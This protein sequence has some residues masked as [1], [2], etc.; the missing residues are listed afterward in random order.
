QLPLAR[1]AR[2][3]GASQILPVGFLLLALSFFSVALFAGTTA[4]DTLWRLLPAVSLVTLLTLGQMLIVPVGMDMIPVFA[5]DKNLGAH[6]G[7][8]S[9]M[10]GA[11]VLA[12]NF[13]LGGLLDRAL[14]PSS[15]AFV[16]WLLMGCIPLCSAV[17]MLFILRSFKTTSGNQ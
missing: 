3:R 2:K 17:A 6:Y 15:Q 9:S 11:T 4:P 13:A 14:I 8:L 16:P 5:R 10:G 12:G 1:F 7:A